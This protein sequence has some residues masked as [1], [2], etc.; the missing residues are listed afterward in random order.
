MLSG[1]NW[2]TLFGDRL[3]ELELSKA[4]L[5]EMHRCV[6]ER[7]PKPERAAATVIETCYGQASP[8]P[9]TF[10][11]SSSA[12]INLYQ[13][14]QS[15]SRIANETRLLCIPPPTAPCTATIS[16]AQLAQTGQTLAFDTRDKQKSG[17][18]RPSVCGNLV[19]Q[20]TQR[21]S[22]IVLHS[23]VATHTH[24]H[25]RTHRTA[26]RLIKFSLA[27]ATADNVCFARC[28]ICNFGALTSRQSGVFAVE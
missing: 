10:N 13:C 22:L 4:E 23:S 11:Y 7:M 12:S 25:T 28:A 1:Q 8:P 15:Q 6:R 2:S 9:T 21:T 3:T 14:K 19:A 17:T 27:S 26:R 18:S 20:K 24:T 16:N 5:T